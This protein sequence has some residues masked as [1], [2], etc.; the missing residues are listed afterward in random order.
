[1]TTIPSTV[2]D[3]HDDPCRWWWCVTVV[4]FERHDVRAGTSAGAIDMVADS[5][6]DSVPV[7]RGAGLSLTFLRLSKRVSQDL[8]DAAFRACVCVS[9]CSLGD[10]MPL[11][12][13]TRY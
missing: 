6:A 11:V 1:M 4:F 10:V 12:W 5:I 2:L 9:Q 7:N 3:G 13:Y 8:W